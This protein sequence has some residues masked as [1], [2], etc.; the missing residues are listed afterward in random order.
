MIKFTDAYFIVQK[1]I[2][3]NNLIAELFSLNQQLEEV[4]ILIKKD[5]IEFYA[6]QTEKIEYI[7]TI[8]HKQLNEFSCG[9]QHEINDMMK[10]LGAYVVSLEL[11]NKKDTL[12]LLINQKSAEIN[13]LQSQ[14]PEK[15]VAVNY[16][17]RYN[18][19]ERC[20]ECII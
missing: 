9:R 4:E 6:T 7:N 14:I 19:K 1:T 18:T 17:I 16:T 2:T 8:L 10:E 3:R 5:M 15:G 20:G 13:Y 12:K 11:I